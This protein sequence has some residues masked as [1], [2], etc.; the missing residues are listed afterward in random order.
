[1]KNKKNIVR[2]LVFLRMVYCVNGC[3][4]EANYRGVPGPTW[5]HLSAEQKQLIVD[6]AYQNEIKKLED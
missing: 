4:P 6:R 5:Q 2:T 3:T 1:M